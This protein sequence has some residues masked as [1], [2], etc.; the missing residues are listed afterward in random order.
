MTNLSTVTINGKRVQLDISEELRALPFDNARWTSSKLIASSPFRDDSSPSF[1]VNL[2]GDHAGIWGDSGAVDGR[3]KGFFTEIIAYCAGTSREEVEQAILERY[4]VLYDVEYSAEEEKS[5]RVETPRIALPNAHSRKCDYSAVI[6]TAVSP[7][8]TKRGIT[9]YAQE[10]YQTGYN[11]VHRGFT[12]LPW[13]DRN[14]KRYA[15]VKYR[16]TSG[17]TFFYE[18]DGEAIASLLY[19]IHTVDNRT[20]TAIICEAEIDALSWASVGY[21]AL[22]TGGGRMSEAQADLIRR[23]GIDT[24]IL[25]GDND[26]AGRQFNRNVYELMRQY[27]MMRVVRLDAIPCVKDANDVLTT[28]GGFALSQAAETAQI[29]RNIPAISIR[30]NA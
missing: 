3:S 26:A 7:Y 29:V 11:V 12:A 21:T 19:G 9:D 2:T 22:A 1:Y 15:N 18:K 8:L 17:K 13:I 23:S 20:R 6:T 30:N 24:L 28:Y 27:V 4:G 5:L 14:G 16:K 25:A 10:L